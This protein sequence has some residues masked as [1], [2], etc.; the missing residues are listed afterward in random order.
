MKRKHTA[1]TTEGVD[2]GEMRN[3]LNQDENLE[4]RNMSHF[5]ILYGS[6]VYGGGWAQPVTG[7]KE[8]R[9]THTQKT[10]Q[11]VGRNIQRECKRTRLCRLSRQPRRA[12]TQA[13]PSRLNWEEL[14]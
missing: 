7:P 4:K 5:S 13:E 11:C 14:R 1:Y 12:R 6:S 9:R 10:Q 8:T 3:E 2:T